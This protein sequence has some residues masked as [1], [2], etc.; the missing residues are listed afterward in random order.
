M[1]KRSIT[2]QCPGA[3]SCCASPPRPT[4]RRRWWA[5][6]WVSSQG[7]ARAPQESGMKL[8]AAFIVQ[9]IQICLFPSNQEFSGGTE[10]WKAFSRLFHFI[11]ST[12]GACY[13]LTVPIHASVCVTQGP[14]VVTA[15]G[16]MPKPARA[17]RAQLC[18]SLFPENQL[19]T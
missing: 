15:A 6:L 4:T 8:S 17:S 11:G 12:E 5:T 9:A 10:G 19:H 14:P 18:T 3:R 13:P 2:P 1:S 7:A 16:E